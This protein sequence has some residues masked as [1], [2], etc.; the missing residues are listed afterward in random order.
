[1]PLKS[2][3]RT[4]HASDSSPN[5]SQIVCLLCGSKAGSQPSPPPSERVS[6]R[7]S[8]GDQAL[9]A[10]VAVPKSIVGVT[11]IPILVHV[12]GTR[13]FGRDPRLDFAFPARQRRKALEQE[14][15]VKQI[16]EEER[17]MAL[18]RLKKAAAVAKQ[19]DED[20]DAEM[21]LL[22][23]VEVSGTAPR[24]WDVADLSASRTRQK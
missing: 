5:R 4:R 16:E 18:E 3:S 14:R 21:E 6:K 11:S 8:A 2:G 23:V 20:R 1:M 13:S 12:Y 7:A 22:E 15:R 9:T 24:I 19:E 17:L 10:L